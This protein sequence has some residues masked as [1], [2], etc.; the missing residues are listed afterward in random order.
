[1]KDFSEWKKHAEVDIQWNGSGR[2][3]WQQRFLTALAELER[4]NKIIDR[5]IGG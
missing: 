1:M 3:E 4:A 2:T 5:I